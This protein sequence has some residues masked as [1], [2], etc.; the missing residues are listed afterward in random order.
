MAK[1]ILL[2]LKVSV[3]LIVFCL[4]LNADAHDGTYLFRR[5]GQLL[6]SLLSMNIVMPAFALL[7]AAAF[8]LSP[9]LEIALIA[10]A[11]SPV[12]PVLPRKIFK[13]G[14]GAPYAVGL[15]AASSLFAILFIPSVLSVFGRILGVP[16]RMS[17][18]AVASLVLTTVLLPIGAGIATRSVAP[19]FADRIARPVSLLATVLL[20]VGVV[21]VLFT[22]WPAV[23]SIVGNGTIVAIVA[24]ICVGIMSGE[25]FGGP[26]IDDRAVLA[27]STASRHPGI[28]IAIARANY[29]ALDQVSAAILLY[30]ITSAVATIPYMLWSRRRASEISH[31]L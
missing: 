4:G 7:V 8:R 17:L 18:G 10:L 31:P 19:D 14:G 30:L 5:P 11:I 26:G 20:I 9:A 2:A 23:V 22:A 27:L 24:F 29:P 6:R 12:P 15:L 16:N 3:F 1:L 13:A 25:L 28:A 21:P